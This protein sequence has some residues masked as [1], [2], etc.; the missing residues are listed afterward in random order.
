MQTPRLRSLLT[1]TLVMLLTA[2]AT[3]VMVSEILDV[4]YLDRSSVRIIA[5]VPDRYEMPH[6]CQLL[7]LD[8]YIYM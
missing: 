1:K 3:N 8:N 6:L 5:S 7:M 4:L 2:T